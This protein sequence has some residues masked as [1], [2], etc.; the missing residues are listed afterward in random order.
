MVNSNDKRWFQ[1]FTFI[2][3]HYSIRFEQF[4]IIYLDFFHEVGQCLLPPKRKKKE[5]ERELGAQCHYTRYC[6][7]RFNLPSFLNFSLITGLFYKALKQLYTKLIYAFLRIYIFHFYKET[8]KKIIF[9]KWI[10]ISCCI[11]LIVKCILLINY[12]MLMLLSYWA[13]GR[14]ETSSACLWPS[15][16]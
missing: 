3:V 5:R 15:R 11:L 9:L 13:V 16:R 14:S 12:R 1:H 2:I 8:N 4:L 6:W 7:C 10:F